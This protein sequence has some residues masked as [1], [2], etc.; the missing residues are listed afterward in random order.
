MAERKN[1]KKTFLPIITQLKSTLMLLFVFIVD[2]NNPHHA[3]SLPV[4]FCY[5]VDS[6]VSG[7]HFIRRR[8][9]KY[10]I[11]SF[12]L[13][14]EPSCF[15]NG[16][17]QWIELNNSNKQN[18]DLSACRQYPR[19]YCSGRGHFRHLSQ[20]GCPGNEI[21]VTEVCVRMWPDARPEFQSSAVVL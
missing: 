5:L 11:N 8:Y 9:K 17:M 1:K 3:V 6:D 13:I 7:L 19:S 12:Q 4:I 20:G 18:N 16:P 15:S 10:S 21:D 14:K 2:I